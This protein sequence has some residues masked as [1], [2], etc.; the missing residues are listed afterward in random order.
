[1]SSK[2]KNLFNSIQFNF[3]FG[4][5]SLLILIGIFFFLWIF[6]S[7]F[8]DNHWEYIFSF[9]WIGCFILGPNEVIFAYFLSIMEEYS[10]TVNYNEMWMG[11]AISFLIPGSHLN[12]GLYFGSLIDGIRGSVLAAIFLYIPCFLFLLGILPQWKYYREKAGI[13]RI[14][15]GLMCSTTGLTLAVVILP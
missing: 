7:V 10:T 13:K 15:E 11:V 4:K 9:Y 6:F 5:P 12:I 1:M 14:Y 3:L 2:S 8:G